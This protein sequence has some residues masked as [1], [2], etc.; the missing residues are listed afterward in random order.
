MV[1][2]KYTAH[3]ETSQGKVHSF[4]MVLSRVN[5]SLTAILNDFKLFLS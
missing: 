1:K 3:S 4:L 2:L 5:V